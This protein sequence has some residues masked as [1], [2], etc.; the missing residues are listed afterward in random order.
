MDK[1]AV[2][3]ALNEIA[4]Y[5]ELS[6]PNPFRS[7]AFEK[8]AHA[9]ETIDGP[10]EALVGTPAL[11]KTPG[12]GKA[13]ANIIEELVRSGTSKYLEELRAQ[14]PPGVFE[15]LRVPKLGLRKIGQLHS[16][17]GIGSLDE[18]EAAGRAG[19]L[20]KLKGFGAKTQEM[21]LKGI[22]FARMRESRF[23][24][25]YGLEVGASLRERLADMES[26]DDCEVAGSVRRRLEV[27]QNVNLVIATAAPEKVLDAIHT[28]GI[29]AELKEVDATTFR[30]RVREEMAVVFH[31]AQPNDF[32][33]T[34]LAATGSAEFLEA[35]NARAAKN[36]CELRGGQLFKNGKR[37]NVA[38]EEDAFERAGIVWVE[39]ERREN[40]DD[41]KLKKPR[42]LLELAQLRGTFHVHT[43]YSDGRNTIAEMLAAASE[44][45]LE[46]VGLSDH[47][48]NA[49]YAGGLTPARLAEQ[50]AELEG[51]R[52]SLAPLRVFRGSEAD[53]LNDGTMDYGAKVLGQFD[54]VIASVHSRF[55]MPK[56]EMTERILLALDDPHVTFLGHMTGR[57]LLSREGYTFD[58]DRVFE[59]AGERGVMIEINGNPNRL[60]IDW[61]H[62]RRALD[63]GV[64]FSINPD[65]HST[66][67]Y[68]ALLTGTWVARKAG[69]S[70]KEIF[71]TRSVEEVTEYL[72]A[73][74]AAH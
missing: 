12:I 30:G 38:R 54:F 52:P 46:Y 1:F 71:N 8:A 27:I 16:E 45:G 10:L 69:L 21:I 36:G 56:D 70:A 41:V 42:P 57:L 60:D 68:G 28:R 39:P 55:S 5:T 23:L 66:R 13:T 49:S 29:V 15:L 51:L 31:F 4:R 40:G 22:A 63:R 53:I 48:Q 37:V 61:R 9:V 6:D 73:R 64:L 74:R 2:A 7:R 72:E 20:A 47:S 34:L 26:V 32:G 3:A 67:E 11:T 17:L 14:Y 35:W 43:T 19:K 59:R 44:R 50:K 18:L 25:P 62:V 33:A 24:L 58:F 65:A